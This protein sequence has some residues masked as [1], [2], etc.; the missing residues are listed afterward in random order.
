MYRFTTIR[1]MLP[2]C[3]LALL[4]SMRGDAQSTPFVSADAGAS[5]GGYNGPLLHFGAGYERNAPHYAL[6]TEVLAGRA[7]KTETGDGAEIKFRAHAFF[8]SSRAKVGGGFARTYLRTSAWSKA[9]SWPEIA[10][11]FTPH[12]MASLLFRYSLP[13]LDRRNGVQGASVALR[14]PVQRRVRLRVDYGL[15]RFHA[16]D[17][18]AVRYSMLSAGGGLEFAIGA[19]GWRSP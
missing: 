6:R 13:N 14:V 19:S 9:A 12:P 7:A 18:A 15:Y 8:G 3:A 10:A 4:V 2:C 1:V 11:L 17:N 5:G 16:T